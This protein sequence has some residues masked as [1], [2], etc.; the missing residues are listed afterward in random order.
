MSPAG[1]L[2]LSVSITGVAWLVERA[3][4]RR[5]R[6]SLRQ[7]AAEWGMKY[8]PLDQLRLTAS[9]ARNFPIV[10]AARIS[11][12]D[13]V[14]GSDEASYRYIFTCHFTTGVLHRK[15]RMARAATFAE[16]RHR[17][18]STAPRIVLAP[19]NLPLIEQYRRLAAD[20]GAVTALHEQQIG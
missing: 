5:R 14:Y 1:L 16:P 12:A 20:V 11:V 6:Q 15:R 18:Q 2:G 8:N 4:R 9:V 17:T 3:G 7:L 19:S 10:G 13:L